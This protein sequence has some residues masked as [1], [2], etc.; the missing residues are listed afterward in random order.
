MRVSVERSKPFV[1]PLLVMSQT[2]VTRLHRLPSD[3]SDEYLPAPV[4]EPHDA[5]EAASISFQSYCEQRGAQNVRGLRMKT[6]RST[7]PKIRCAVE[8]PNWAPDGNNT[9]A[10]RRLI[11]FKGFVKL[12]HYRMPR[13]M[14]QL[15][16]DD[17]PLL[18]PAGDLPS[19]PCQD[20][21]L[22]LRQPQE[23]PRIIGTL[24]LEI[25]LSDKNYVTAEQA[26]P[27]TSRCGRKS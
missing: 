7:M 19:F 8:P 18:H 3:N 16:L 9:A 20:Y 1:A 10:Q 25:P 17:V 14:M 6:I 21:L 12:K 5:L 15:G 11:H 2:G 22:Q 23:Q 4:N 26:E 13:L 24:S 27:S